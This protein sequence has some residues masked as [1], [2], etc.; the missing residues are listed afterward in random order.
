M[1]GFLVS[2]SVPLLYLRRPPAEGPSLGITESDTVPRPDEPP[3]LVYRPRPDNPFHAKIYRDEAV[4]HLWIE[5]LGWYLVDARG[6]EIVVPAGA[7]QIP[8][9]ERLWGIPTSLCAI[10]LGAHPIHASC[11]EIDGVAMLLAAPG[12]FGKTTLAAAAHLAGYRL[13]SEDATVCR[14]GE[15]PDVLPGPAL[16]RLR[17]D[18]FEQMALHDVEIVGEDPDRVHLAL[19]ASRRGTADPVPIAGLVLL[20]VADELRVERVGSQEAIQEL[21]SLSFRLPT[22]EDRVRCF[23][24]TAELASRVPVWNLYRPLRY[25]LLD[26]VLTTIAELARGA[27][28]E[29]PG[30]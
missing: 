23:S 2:S 25:D 7:A 4:T 6:R 9:E 8:R 3:L 11:V 26:D 16:I 18:S 27:V 15:R 29:G 14:P 30:Q 28:R 13:L 24:G 10:T 19:D 21:W 17:R 1:A 5:G 22:D 12:R 20:R